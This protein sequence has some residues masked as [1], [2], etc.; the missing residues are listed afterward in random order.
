MEAFAVL[1]STSF[2][3]NFS[4]ADLVE[5]LVLVKHVAARL[6]EQ[7]FDKRDFEWSLCNRKTGMNAAI[8]RSIVSNIINS[9][10]EKEFE[11]Y[12]TEIETKTGCT[13]IDIIGMMERIIE[14]CMVK[15][16]N[17]TSTCVMMQCLVNVHMFDVCAF[18][19]TPLLH[20]DYKN[21]GT[22]VNT[23]KIP[24]LKLLVGRLNA[25]AV[26]GDNQIQEKEPKH[27]EALG[28]C[29]R[30]K[31]KQFSTLERLI[32]ASGSKKCL[33]CMD[34]LSPSTHFIIQDGCAHLRCI[35]CGYRHR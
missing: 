9:S 19:S 13:I 10:S 3:E 23:V 16:L 4:S 6:R 14:F 7:V 29:L 26:H 2:A 21:D 31:V 25:S 30:N 5:Y 20:I 22:D 18:R 15:L 27:V 28:S 1:A 17:I 24:Q 12:N 33:S 35:D 34:Q 32:A 11:T 8:I